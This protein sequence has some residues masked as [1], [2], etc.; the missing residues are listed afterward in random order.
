[1][2]AWAYS[3]AQ[4]FAPLEDDKGNV[5]WRNDGDELRFMRFMSAYGRP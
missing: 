1:L 4:K 2:D 5:H 3:L